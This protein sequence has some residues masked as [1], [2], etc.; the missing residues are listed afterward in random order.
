M[1]S[2]AA[3]ARLTLLGAVLIALALVGC[4]EQPLAT[5]RPVQ[6]AL[7]WFPEHEHGGY[8]AALTDGIY[9]A[10]GLDVR[11][12]PGGP[13][14]PVIARVASGD[15]DFGVLN[16]DDVVT[17]RAASAPLVALF[18]PIQTSPWCIMVHRASGIERLIDLHDLTL[19]IQVSA[20]QY[21]FLRRH[22]PLPGVTA[23]PYT[24]SIAEFLINPRY[25]QQAYVI[26][27]PLLATAN[28]GDPRCLLLADLGFDPYTSVLVTREDL[29]TTQPELVSRV[30]AAS[31]DG[32][33]RYVATPERGNAA[34][35]AVNPQIGRET[36]TKGAAAL[37]PLIQTGAAL[38]SM[39]GARWDTLAQ[40]LVT[41]GAIDA[42]PEPH[43]CFSDAA[44]P[45]SLAPIP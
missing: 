7:N 11:L 9:T 33:Q 31:R 27:E 45:A 26:S 15:V 22:A 34:I 21:Q 19:A 43:T 36:L 35:L 42:A 4:A 3:V 25:A 44:R 8:Y 39:T 23:V 29:L 17:A 18:A 5:N 1:G 24:G 2:I 14:A 30:V 10:A 28:G 41:I 16:A 37:R 13:G 32:W 6:I 40:Q 12:L 38:G 20:A